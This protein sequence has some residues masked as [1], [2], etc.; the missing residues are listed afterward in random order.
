[1][2]GNYFPLILAAWLVVS[3]A[4]HPAGYD[5]LGHFQALNTRQHIGKSRHKLSQCSDHLKKRGI[6]A[7]A[8]TR[9]AAVLETYRQKLLGAG[10]VSSA[11]NT[12]AKN[13]FISQ[14]IPDDS[15]CVLAPEATIG[16]FWV[17]G[18]FIRS[19]ITD[20]QA[21]IPLVV[22][23]Q[24]IDVNTCEPIENLYW[25][26]WSCNALGKYSGVL[27]H[28]N[29]PR[30][31]LNETFLR[32]LQRTDT[33]GSAQFE[34]I[35][36]GHYGGRATHIHLLAHVGASVLPN[37][38]LTGGHIPHI[39]QLFF[40]QSLIE[41]VET[42]QPYRTNE[43]PVTRNSEDGIFHE[44]SDGGKYDPVAKYTMIGDRISD[45]ILV[46]VTMG[47]D[48]SASYRADYAAELTDHGGIV[49][50]H[51]CV[52]Y[53]LFLSLSSVGLSMPTSTVLFYFTIAFR[54]LRHF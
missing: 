34:T 22:H 4:A 30:S 17:R 7:I 9:R 5:E 37:K 45:G 39:S 52:L 36:P 44:A 24:F 21:G 25:E 54:F 47:I 8:E 11:Y 20:G 33:D 27:E 35:F 1:M 10:S 3:C 28:S 2:L 46:S 50:R 26:I 48:I 6:Q 29:S 40:D 12:D 13:P 31:N 14:A 15:V 23:A 41:A 38:T 53:L 42:H 19:N 32:G 49:H 18:E 43:D 16:P 51:G